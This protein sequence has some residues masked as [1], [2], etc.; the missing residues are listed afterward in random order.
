MDIQY[1]NLGLSSEN[2]I[3]SSENSIKSSE[4]INLFIK[5]GPRGEYIT[6]I[7]SNQTTKLVPSKTGILLPKA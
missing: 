4:V 1:G 6:I 2:S 3:K 7:R 5:L